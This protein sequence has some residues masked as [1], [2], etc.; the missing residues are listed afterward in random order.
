VLKQQTAIHTSK[1]LPPEFYEQL[2]SEAKVTLWR[3]GKKYKT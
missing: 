3:R 2:L 1:E